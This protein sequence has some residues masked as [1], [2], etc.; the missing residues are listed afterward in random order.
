MQGLEQPLTPPL[1]LPACV[2]VC[3]FSP[4]LLHFDTND[5]LKVKLRPPP[6]ILWLFTGFTSLMT[7]GSR[8]VKT[9]SFKSVYLM[10]HSQIHLVCVILTYLLSILLL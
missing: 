6:Q 4:V 9:D 8:A 3:A 1:H 7:K 2:C 10:P 5:W